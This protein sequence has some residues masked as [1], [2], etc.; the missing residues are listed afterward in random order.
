MR[1]IA[2]LKEMGILTRE[3]GR[4]EGRWVVKGTTEQ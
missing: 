2:A 1:E 4:K 3:G